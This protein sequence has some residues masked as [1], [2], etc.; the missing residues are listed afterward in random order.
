MKLA[1][2]CAMSENRVIGRDNGLP[3]HLSEDLKYFKRTT[4]GN[5]MI[6]G[7]NTWE[8]IGRAL[9]GRTSIVITS[10]PNYQ[11]EGA[12][13]VGSLAE[14]VKLAETV[15]KEAGSTEAFVIGGAVLYQAALPMAD[16]LHLTRVH[17]AVEG[18][19]FLHEFDETNWNEIS[20]E[21]YKRDEENHYDYSICVLERLN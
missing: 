3:W 4:M 20:R 18:D 6:M 19:T 16:T 11:A 9:P 5:C 8:S 2:I 10:D 1:L 17:A 12:E 14:A 7:R 15:S 21:E 13:V